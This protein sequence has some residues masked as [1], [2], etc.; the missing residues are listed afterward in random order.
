MAST[1]KCSLLAGPFS[2]FVQLSLAVIAL[3]EGKLVE[4]CRDITDSCSSVGEL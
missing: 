3:G 4:P 2:D 1:G